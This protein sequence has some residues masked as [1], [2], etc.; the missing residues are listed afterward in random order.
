MAETTSG[1]SDRFKN[2]GTFVLIVRTP[3]TLQPKFRVTLQKTYLRDSIRHIQIA[4]SDTFPMSQQRYEC[5][6]V[7]GVEHADGT[8]RGEIC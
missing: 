4:Y 3:I 8:T 7:T 5:D 2:L 6:S 1:K